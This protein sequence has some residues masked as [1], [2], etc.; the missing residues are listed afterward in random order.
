MLALKLQRLSDFPTHNFRRLVDYAMAY[1]SASYSVLRYT[2]QPDVL[3]RLINAL[4]ATG[5]AAHCELMVTMPCT[6]D[7]KRGVAC[8]VPCVHRN[9]ER[10]VPNHC[11][12]IT[13]AY[14]GVYMK[15]SPAQSDPN[16][17]YYEIKATDEEIYRLFAFSVCFLG[18]PYRADF[19]QGPAYFYEHVPDA[20]PTRIYA[21]Y[22]R[23]D[24]DL[25]YLHVARNFCKEEIERGDRMR[26]QREEFDRANPAATETQ[27]ER[28]VTKRVFEQLAEVLQLP[29][30]TTVETRAAEIATKV[31]NFSARM[32]MSD[33]DA[34]M[35]SQDYID[36]LPGQKF[37]FTCVQFACA[38]L[39]FAGILSR[40]RA[41][42]D[43]GRILYPANCLVHNLYAALRAEPGRVSDQSSNHAYGLMVDPQSTAA[44]S[45]V[46]VPRR[47]RPV[48]DKE[49][50]AILDASQ[51]VNDAPMA[52]DRV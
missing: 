52:S 18:S 38:A 29:P 40:C 33:G 20:I 34:E 31:A 15:E 4:T 14:E 24:L 37:T 49:R 42:E 1:L 50:S 13:C 47:P 48:P 9:G 2:A 12:A 25:A 26:E 19:S 17:L 35:D 36:A 43:S 3:T 10:V 6:L 44:K 7:R 8:H 16:W 11:V 23:T 46:F 5:S 28:F 22:A 39:G 41:W 51:R 30:G 32:L 21:A 45:R 27:R